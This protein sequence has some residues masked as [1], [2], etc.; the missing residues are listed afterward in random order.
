MFKFIREK[1]T[2][3]NTINELSKLTERELADI[4]INRSEIHKIAK[5][6]ELY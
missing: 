4:G 6:T 5:R 1:I 3:R 2:Q